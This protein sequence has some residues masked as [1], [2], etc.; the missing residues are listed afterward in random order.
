[1]SGDAGDNCQERKCERAS[2]GWSQTHPRRVD[3]Q[4]PGTPGGG[5]G[6]LVVGLC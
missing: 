2:G 5:P 6:S 1:V 4:K 3:A